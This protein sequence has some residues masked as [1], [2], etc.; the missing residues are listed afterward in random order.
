MS[1]K[2]GRQQWV[3]TVRPSN[4][5]PEGFV[6][7]FADLANNGVLT[8]LSPTGDA[9]PL[10]G[11]DSAELSNEPPLM[12]G[13]ASQGVGTKAAREDHIHP[14]DTSKAD[15]THNHADTYEPANSNIQAHIGSTNNPHGVTI[16][17]IGAAA[18]SHTHPYASESHT[19]NYAG[20]ASAGGPANSVQALLKRGTGIYGS[21]YDGS[22]EREWSVSYGNTSYTACVGDDP[23]L[24][25][26]RT[27]LPHSHGN[28]DN[29]GKIS[30]SVNRPLRTNADG[31]IIN[32]DWGDYPGTF[33][34]GSDPRLSDARTPLSHSHGNISNAG[35]VIG[36]AQGTPFI[37]GADGVIQA[38]SWGTTSGTACQGND[39]RLSDARTPLSHT[40]GNISNVG[41]IGTTAN[42]PIITGTSGVLQAGDWHS[43]TPAAPTT[44]GAVGTSNSYAR[45]DHSHPS[46]IATSAPTS[47][48]DGDIWMV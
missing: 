37:A 29:A 3:M 34:Q 19:H 31:D 5:P 48:V 22:V 26:A 8:V 28:M 6:E 39:P 10:G 33:C 14:S 30:N 18:A 44:S 43:V 32:G 27:P 42:L 38:G 17:Q 15:A 7:I 36:A 21:N 1:K 23:R 20:S 11:A 9:I 4:N 47:P 41:A 45:G 24:S 40:H 13:A 35:Q 2:Y 46:R 12:D 25:D 16:G